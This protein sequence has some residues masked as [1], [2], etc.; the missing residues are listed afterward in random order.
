[1]QLYS[2]LPSILLIP[3]FI[4]AHV[5]LVSGYIRHS[6]RPEPM[7]E[8]TQRWLWLLYPL[9]LVLFPVLQMV[10]FTSLAWP[11]QIMRQQSRAIPS[12]AVQD[13]SNLPLLT[14]VAGVIAIGLSVLLLWFW[15]Q[16]RPED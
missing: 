7:P 6:I 13:Y 10:L 4:A 11:L 15:F 16:R 12:T 5:L 9:G 14:W 8:R 2:S 3:V 1:M